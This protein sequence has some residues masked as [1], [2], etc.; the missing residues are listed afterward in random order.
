MP[1]NSPAGPYATLSQEVNQGHQ[2][3]SNLYGKIE[4]NLGPDARVVA[5]FTSFTHPVIISDEDGDMLEE[6]LRGPQAIGK[7]LFLLINSPGGDGIA[8]ERI[9]NICRT[10]SADNKFSVIVPKRAKSA[11]TMICLG[12][13]KIYMSATSEL[14]PI[15]P[16]IATFSNRGR[17]MGFQAAH[18]IINSYE[19]LIQSAVK[20]KGNLEPYLHQLDIYDA[21]EIKGMRS[22]QALSESIAIKVLKGGMLSG[23]AVSRIKAAIKPLT[24][25][26]YTKD[27]GRPIYD[28]EAKKCGLKVE[29]CEI[30]GEMWG[31]VW[32][33]YVRLNFFVGAHVSKVI[34]SSADSATV[35]IPVYSKGES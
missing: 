19:E 21:R 10:Y 7:R 20:T 33:L 24:D 27:H 14:G 23:V 18:E 4:K 2:T 26:N 16:Q 35:A 15:D 28:N 31:A 34:E 6:I 22:A 17:F 5:F 30:A 3:R 32:E 13:E 12:G 11:A 9:V 1:I 25:P 8:A 29:T